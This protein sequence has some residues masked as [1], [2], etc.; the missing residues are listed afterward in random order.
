MS[1]PRQIKFL[2]REASSPDL[3]VNGP[4]KACHMSVWSFASDISP[5]SENRCTVGAHRG[6]C[7]L[8]ARYA[9][10]RRIRRST[11]AEDPVESGP[12]NQNC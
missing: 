12:W 8:S 2:A 9:L 10:L 11:R 1:V 5:E 7:R 3:A 6:Q 4:L